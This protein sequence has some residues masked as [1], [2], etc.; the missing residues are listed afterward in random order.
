MDRVMLPTAMLLAS[1]SKHSQQQHTSISEL[2]WRYVDPGVMKTLPSAV[3]MPYDAGTLVEELKAPKNGMLRCGAA[4]SP[5]GEL[6][7]GLWL[8]REW[9]SASAHLI[10]H[11]TARKQIL[12]QNPSVVCIGCDGCVFACKRTDAMYLRALQ[13]PATYERPLGITQQE[14]A[15]QVMGTQA[16]CSH[17]QGRSTRVLR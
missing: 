1:Y 5:A 6:A 7:E 12:V 16:T 2:R 4:C 13:P 14:C 8:A 9:S 17:L 3:A 15:A 11:T 10:C